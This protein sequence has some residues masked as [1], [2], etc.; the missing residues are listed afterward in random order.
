M[1]WHRMKPLKSLI[2]CLDNS[3]SELRQFV[4]GCE[5][6]GFRNDII[7]F[8]LPD[9]RKSLHYF[10]EFT[11]PR[12]GEGRGMSSL[13]VIR[14][15][16]EL[17]SSSYKLARLLMVSHTVAIFLACLRRGS[18]MTPHIV[19]I[20]DASNAIN[21]GS[22]VC[23]CVLADESVCREM[24]VLVLFLV[25]A[26]NTTMITEWWRAYISRAKPD[27]RDVKYCYDDFVDL[28]E[29]RSRTTYMYSHF[30]LVPEFNTT[31]FATYLRAMILL[32]Q[33]SDVIVNILCKVQSCPVF[34]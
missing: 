27:N 17:D 9:L 29:A 28:W 6:A 1:T 31:F 30:E 32:L 24:L 5:I 3:S 15:N 12:R 22:I 16:G 4:S 14:I 34:T 8:I 26:K 19:A 10:Y 20:S 7:R 18:N 33:L 23:V 25:I 11:F 21:P 13:R 2:V